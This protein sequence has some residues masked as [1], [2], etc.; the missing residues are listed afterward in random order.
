MMTNGK[1]ELIVRRVAGHIGTELELEMLCS[2]QLKVF[3]L[4]NKKS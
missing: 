4:T 3:K 1:I 2:L